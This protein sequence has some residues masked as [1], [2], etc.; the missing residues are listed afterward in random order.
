MQWEFL[1]FNRFAWIV[2][3]ALQLSA[4]GGDDFLREMQ[5]KAAK[6]NHANWGHWG[7][8]V[9]H[10]AHSSRHSNRLVPVYTYGIDLNEVSGRNSLY[11]SAP[12]LRRLYGYLPEKTLNPRAN[13][14]DQTDVCRLQWQAINSGKKNIVLIVFDGLDWQLANAAAIYRTRSVA[15]SS[16]RGSGLAF[17]DYGETTSDF[18]SFVTSPQNSGTAVDVNAQF[19]KNPGGTARGGYFARLGGDT[20]WSKSANAHYLLGKHRRFGH[21]VTDSASSATSMTSGIKTYNGAVNVDAYGQHV[22]PIA[23]TLQQQGF[24]IGVVS[25]VS[26]SHATPACA[27]ANNVTRADYQDISRDL[28]GLRSV[29][30]RFD[31]LPGVDVLLGA[32]WGAEASRDNGQGNNFQPG[33]RF[34][35]EEDF[36]RINVANGGNYVVA[37][38]QP[39]RS[40]NA[41][42][43][44]AAWQAH[45]HGARLFGYFGAQGGHLPYK[46]AD[47]K[48]DSLNRRYSDADILENPSLAQ[49]T[50]AALGVLSANPNGF[51]LMIEA[52]DVDWAAHSNNIDDAIGAT[53]SGD[54]AFRMVTDWVEIND[55]WED[56]VVIVT[57][58]HGH[59]FVL[60]Q[61]EALAGPSA[62]PDKS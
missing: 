42:L 15:Y 31:P 45:Q 10:Y 24:G 8:S 27:Y 3:L 60:D 22:I 35:A 50:R 37:V 32:G 51:W 58:D 16:G 11:R 61:P 4:H 49:M 18:G 13:Y 46:T 56:T 38:R 7:S 14:F 44:D 23:R 20:P 43:M 2:I 47:G 21:V 48:Y 9:R 12:A 40:G 25:S 41:V 6:E 52:G 55:A 33:N 30:H 39:G 36:A 53:F 34:L 26:I 28:L 57:A 5:R 17:Q 29:S 54:D 19:V 62:S 59:Y 1:T